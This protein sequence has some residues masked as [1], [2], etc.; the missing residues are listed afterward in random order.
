[1]SAGSIGTLQATVG[2]G[3]QALVGPRHTAQLRFARRVG[4]RYRPIAGY[5][6]I[7]GWLSEPEALRLFDLA[8]ERRARPPV[9]VEIGSWLGRSSVVIA[10]GLL[11][12]SPT[13]TLHC[14]DPWDCA[15]EDYARP[16]YEAIADRQPLPLRE[17]F[18]AN[19]RRFGVAHVVRQHVG[20]SADV[21]LD[22][23]GQ[24][25]LLFIDANHDYPAVLEDFRLW[26]SYLAPGGVVAFHD[27]DH[28]G[29]RAVID[30]FVRA[31]PG[32]RDRAQVD[33]LFHARR[34]AAVA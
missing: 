7:T 20:L 19:V 22:F 13:P 17:Q 18:A 25:D 23:T 8:R 4:W 11:A 10:K 12:A 32:W 15:G 2:R 30:E 3:L 5:R 28:E 21:A 27:A 6:E 16:E 14:V 33:S 34:A 29:P 1:M 9:A 31:A 26:S 24:I